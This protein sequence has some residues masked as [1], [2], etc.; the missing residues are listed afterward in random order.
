MTGCTLGLVI[1]ELSEPSTFADQGPVESSYTIPTASSLASTIASGYP[2]V[3]GLSGG[4]YP[5]DSN[6][7]IIYTW[8]DSFGNEAT[9][10]FTLRVQRPN[11]KYY[12]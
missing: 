10:Q 12:V 2:S 4:F 9:C 1:Y 6:H 3:T 5:L 7:V 8:A 11:S